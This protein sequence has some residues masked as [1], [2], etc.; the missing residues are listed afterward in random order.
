MLRLGACHGIMRLP[1]SPA[2]ALD[3][4]NTA[5]VSPVYYVMFTTLTILASL[6]MFRVGGG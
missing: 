6:I 5:I 1:W 3:L 2:Q 4:Y